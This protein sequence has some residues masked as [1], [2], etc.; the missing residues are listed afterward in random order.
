MMKNVSNKELRKKRISMSSRINSSLF[1]E[2]LRSTARAKL[3]TETLL[4]LEEQRV[5]GTFP[6]NEERRKGMSVPM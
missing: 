2:T 3:A 4:S 6:R 1:E 5:D